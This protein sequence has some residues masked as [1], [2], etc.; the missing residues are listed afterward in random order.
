MKSARIAATILPC[1]LP[2]SGCAQTQFHTRTS[3]AHAAQSQA[4][5]TIINV[6][7]LG[8]MPQAQLAQI[9]AEISGNIPVQNGAELFRI[10]YWTVLKG[11]PTQAS[12]LISVPNTTAPPKGVVMYLHGTNATRATAPSQL[13][14]VD[15]N[16]ETAIFAGNG[17]YTVLPDY[18]GMGVSQLPQAYMITKPQVDASIDMLR[19][20]H[21]VAKHR[22]MKWSPNLTMMGFSQGGQVVAGV[23]RELDQLNLPNY[24]LL[25]SIGVAG[26]YNLRATSLPNAIKNGC[27]QCVGYMTWAAY[28]YSV[29]YGHDLKSALQPNYVDSVPKLFDGSKTAEEIGGA[30]PEDPAEMFEPAFLAAMKNNTD[31]WF[32]QALNE[33]E[34]DAWVPVAPFQLYF[35]QKDEDVPEAAS[36]ALFD[37]AKPRGGN[38]SLHSLGPIDHQTSVAM[39]YAPAL[40]WFNELAG[41]SQPEVRRERTR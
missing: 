34:T 25:G 1:I 20:V 31:N 30:L 32:T 18:I 9:A 7:P 8:V 24:R 37:Y 33:N 28:A 6:E 11:K 5:G 23:A 14:R 29:Y 16:E 41:Q 35:G 22:H 36:H 12:G 19:A 40:A 26:P 2:L 13:D 27:R 3:S 38:I 21:Q 15:G 10:T 17:F 4:R 39:T